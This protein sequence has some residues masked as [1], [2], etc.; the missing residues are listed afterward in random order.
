MNA[1]ERTAAFLLS[2]LL[3]A[4]AAALTLLT[5]LQ[6]S[7]MSLYIVLSKSMEP[8]VPHGSLALVRKPGAELH[9]ADIVV[10]R[11]EGHPYPIMHRIVGIGSDGAYTVK[12]DANS[13]PDPLPVVDGQ[14]AGVYVAHLPLVGML[15]YYAQMWTVPLGLLLA[16]LLVYTLMRL[17][18]RRRSAD[19]P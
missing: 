12:G 3:I 14:L 18:Q 19:E 8:T 6:I 17:R 5:A 10:Y 15:V 13:K 2:A 4:A 11:M 7:G 16:G 9:N 1:R